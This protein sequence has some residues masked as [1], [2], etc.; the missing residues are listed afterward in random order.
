[1]KVPTRRRR[2]GCP[3]YADYFGWITSMKVHTQRRGNPAGSGPLHLRLTAL[4]ESPRT[5]AGKCG[6]ATTCLRSAGQPSMKVPALMRGN[7][8]VGER[9]RRRAAPLN[10]SP[11]PNAGKFAR[12]GALLL[13]SGGTSMKVPARRRRNRHRRYPQPMPRFCLNESP[14]PKTGKWILQHRSAIL[15]VAS[16]KVSARRRRNAGTLPSGSAVLSPQ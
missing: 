6:D 11:R 12:R 7:S 2:N 15:R 14:H 16:M 4:N 3:V 13:R 9:A 5:K 10:E 1:M 8:V